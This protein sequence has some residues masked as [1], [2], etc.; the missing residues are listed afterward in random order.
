MGFLLR[1]SW[2]GC[3]IFKVDGLV[4]H[5]YSYFLAS[6]GTVHIVLDFFARIVSYVI[7]V[8]RALLVFCY[9]QLSRIQI[10]LFSWTVSL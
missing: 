8:A 10:N 7:F 4:F 1:R 2:Y 9:G 5:F 3:T 6:Y